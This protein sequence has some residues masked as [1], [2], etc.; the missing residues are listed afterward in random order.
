MLEQR[1]FVF[2][3]GFRFFGRGADETESFRADA[4]VDVMQASTNDFRPRDVVRLED[5]DETSG[6]GQG[7]HRRQRVEGMPQ[8]NFL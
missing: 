6:F 2:G 1:D 4:V 8:Q 7:N 3:Y 5:L